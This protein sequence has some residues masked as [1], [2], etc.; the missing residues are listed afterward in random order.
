MTRGHWWKKLN[1]AQV[2]YNGHSFPN[3]SVD[4]STNGELLVDLTEVPDERMWYVVYPSD[5]KVGL[6]NL[7]HFF[8]LPGYVYSEYETPL[9]VF[10]KSAKAETDPKVAVSDHSVEFTPLR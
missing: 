6:P 3:A 10:M 2:V 5:K 1:S 9:V 8:F 4:R 7:R